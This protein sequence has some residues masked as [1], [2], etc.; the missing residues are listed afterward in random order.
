[1]GWGCAFADFDNDGW[2]DL[3]VANGHVYPEIDRAGRGISYLQPRILYRNLGNGRFADISSAAGAAILEP[4]S[5]RG[6]AVGD[7]D[8]DGTIEIVVNNMNALPSLLRLDTKSPN[9]WIGIQAIGAKSNRSG[10]GARITCV[11]GKHR[12]VGEIRSGGSHFS[13]NDLRVHF[14]LGST[15][16]VDLIEVQWPS[17]VTDRVRGVAADRYVQIREGSGIVAR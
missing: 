4:S 6:V 10:I 12:Q 16:R 5:G 3:F 11:T 2:P 15:N 9:H 1:V 7:L 17:G 14:G 13:Q 8:N